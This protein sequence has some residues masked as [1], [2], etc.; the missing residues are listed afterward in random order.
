MSYST[1]DDVIAEFKGI[2]F[3]IDDPVT[4]TTVEDFI[5]QADAYIDANINSRYVV[6]VTGTTSLIILKTI[7]VWLVADRISRILQVKTKTEETQTAEKSLKQMADDLLKQI[8]NGILDLIDATL[9]SSGAGFRSYANDEDLKYTFK[10]NS[11][12]W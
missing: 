7:S 1:V 3:T 6:P 10:K 4:D 5:E 8:S 12:Q 9:Q 11:D 2:S